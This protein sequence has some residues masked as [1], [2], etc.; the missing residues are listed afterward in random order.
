M[1]AIEGKSPIT[2]EGYRFLAAKFKDN[3][4]YALGIFSH[5]FLLLSWNLMARCVY[6]VFNH[7]S[8]N[9]DALTIVFPKHKG[10]QE[11]TFAFPKHVYA[12]PNEPSICP[13]LALAIYIFFRNES[14]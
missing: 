2:F 10:D 13:I 9:M 11:G 3:K 8:W 12:N 14:C 5:V 4:D 6:N 7:I 1:S